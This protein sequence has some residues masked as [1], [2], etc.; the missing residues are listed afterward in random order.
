MEVMFRI[1]AAYRENLKLLAKSYLGFK[2]F[3]RLEEEKFHDVIN[4]LI[5]PLASETP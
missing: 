1:N 5:I 4:T 2:I 3:H